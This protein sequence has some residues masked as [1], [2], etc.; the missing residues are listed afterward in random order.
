MSENGMNK[1]SRRRE[2]YVGLE[3]RV[4]AIVYGNPGIRPV[5]ITEFLQDNPKFEGVEGN[6][7]RSRLTR[8]KKK[9][10]VYNRKGLYFVQDK[11]H[12][13]TLLDTWSGAVRPP[14]IPKGRGWVAFI[15]LRD[16]RH[17]YSLGEIYKAISKH[18]DVKRGTVSKW[19]QRLSDHT[20]RRKFQGRT[21]YKARDRHIEH[22]EKYSA[23][24]TEYIIR[25]P[26]KSVCTPVFSDS[27]QSEKQK[28][29]KKDGL[30]DAPSG[31]L[32][33]VDDESVS[34]PEANDDLLPH[35]PHTRSDDRLGDVQFYD[36]D[37]S[38]RIRIS[39]KRRTFPL[40]A[41]VHEDV[42]QQFFNDEKVQVIPMGTWVMYMRAG[43]ME[44]KT[45]YG[46][47]VYNYHL[48]LKTKKF[49]I[50]LSPW[51]GFDPLRMDNEME[52]MLDDIV[53]DLLRE[54][55][56]PFI[57]PGRT[58]WKNQ[59][60]E[61]W[62]YEEGWKLLTAG[63]RADTKEQWYDNHRLYKWADMSGTM[64]RLNKDAPDLGTSTADGKARQMQSQVFKD[65][66]TLRN[67][68]AI[69]DVQDKQRVD[70]Q[71]LD[72]IN[73]N[74]KT[75]EG[76]MEEFGENVVNILKKSSKP[77]EKEQ[78]IKELDDQDKQMYG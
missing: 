39:N 67:H 42:R 24:V 26:E 55:G 52:Q 75:F 50:H 58:I 41:D 66:I 48:F 10:L 71:K 28:K 53:M 40:L 35:P 17:Y 44:R 54:F 19:V 5:R 16:I 25:T 76:K 43:K 12:I 29:P 38:P 62:D 56:S 46:Y 9:G 64:Y 32:N 60:L 31:T 61:H 69:R 3:R 30:A 18:I 68:E 74:L 15:L 73:D 63:V 51:E 65:E 8:L 37:I 49:E 23:M 6:S 77:D 57:A 47:R 45:K 11:E 34:I 72:E 2:K 7:V 59:E 1:T 33:S 27:V 14:R 36:E 20:E 22:L 70:R 21:K 4:L 13:A 78:K